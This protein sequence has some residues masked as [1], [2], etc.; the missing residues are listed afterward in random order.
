[1]YVWLAIGV[2]G[3]G[4][5]ATAGVCT[6]AGVTGGV[7]VCAWTFC[8]T[9]VL[10]IFITGFTSVLLF[11]FTTGIG[12]CTGVE[13]TT[14]GVVA[15]TW[16]LTGV[17]TGGVTGTAGVVTTVAV[18]VAGAVEV[19]T[20]CSFVVGTIGLAGTVPTIVCTFCADIIGGT[21]A[22][23]GATS[24]VDTSSAAS[25]SIVFVRYPSVSS[26]GSLSI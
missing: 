12:A 21:L 10:G 7:F 26:P 5:F 20:G 3:P 23:A 22:V 4:V 24:V 15:F 1:M 18:C 2:V 19:A 9:V 6:G 25:S 16:V 13:L 17:V 8:C 14:V 11:K